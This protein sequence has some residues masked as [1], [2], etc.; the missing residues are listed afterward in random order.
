MSGVRTVSFRTWPHLVLNEGRQGARIG[1]AVLREGGVPA[2]APNA[3]VLGLPVPA[4]MAGRV[5][6]CHITSYHACEPHSEL[7]AGRK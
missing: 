2:D 6:S 7:T 1:H 4:A 5:M 3:V